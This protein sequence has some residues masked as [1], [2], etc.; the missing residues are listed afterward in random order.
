MTHFRLKT[1]TKI[2]REL[3]GDSSG[4]EHIAN[5]I[6]SNCKLKKV[7]ANLCSLEQ[8]EYNRRSIERPD[9]LIE[10]LAF[11]CYFTS[12]LEQVRLLLV[13]SLRKNSSL[14][15]LRLYNGPDDEVDPKDCHF[16]K[17]EYLPLLCDRSSIDETYN[18]N[19]TLQ[20]LGAYR[21]ENHDFEFSVESIELLHYL[22]L[23]G[24]QTNT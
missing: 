24:K 23:T 11:D 3:L 14:K 22:P 16:K 2:T 4:L 13:E 5:G 21:D 6:A 10:E 12:D 19:H 18:S 1:R 7:G 8:L 20:A 17:R 15:T 9:C